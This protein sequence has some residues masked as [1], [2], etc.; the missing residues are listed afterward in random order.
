MSLMEKFKSHLNISI[1]KIYLFYV[2]GITFYKKDN[3]IMHRT[4]GVN[5]NENFFNNIQIAEKAEAELFYYDVINRKIYLE[6]K[7]D[8]KFE[9][10]DDIIFH[11]EKYSSPIIIKPNENIYIKDEINQL[12]LK[13]IEALRKKIN[14][15]DRNFQDEFF[16]P[17]QK[18]YLKD[19]H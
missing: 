18:G 6:N 1:E 3:K 7:N 11:A 5:E 2:T 4:W 16:S 10:I 17:I 19:N 13:E 15:I 9:P 8:S 12:E 14:K